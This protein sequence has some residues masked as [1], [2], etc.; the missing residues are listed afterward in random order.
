M[1]TYQDCNCLSKR[2][3]VGA[4]TSWKGVAI[5]KEA[6]ECTALNPTAQLGAWDILT[7]GRNFS[8]IYSERWDLWQVQ[9][10]CH[11]DMVEAHWRTTLS[12]RMA[13]GHFALLLLFQCGCLS[14]VTSARKTQNSHIN[15]PPSNPSLLPDYRR[16]KVPLR[17]YPFLFLTRPGSCTKHAS[18]QTKGLANTREANCW[19][20]PDGHS[21]A[22]H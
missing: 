10:P 3:E 9:S 16:D 1:E 11:R 8:L 21:P 7:A 4:D 6:N 20:P 22:G 15:H 14:E 18:A 5:C 19:K 2:K 13:E 17:G 12:F